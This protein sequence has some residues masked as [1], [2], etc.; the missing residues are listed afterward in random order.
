[1]DRDVQDVRGGLME[2]RHD[3]QEQRGFCSEVD[4]CRIQ[5]YEENGKS[6]LEQPRMRSNA[7]RLGATSPSRYPTSLRGED[8]REAR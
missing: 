7:G 5:I 3:I 2:K 6:S 4:R 8:A 1:M